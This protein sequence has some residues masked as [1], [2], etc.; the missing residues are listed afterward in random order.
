MAHDGSETS[1]IEQ[2]IADTLAALTDSGSSLPGNK[3]FKTA[4]KWT[5][6]V[7]ADSSGAEAF[8]RYAPFAFVSYVPQYA[9]REGGDDLRQP[10]EFAVAIGIVSK[11]AGVARFG[12][13]GILGANKIEQLVI[14]AIDHKRP[15]DA[16]VKC[17]DL[18]F[19]GSILV[20]DRPTVRQIQ[21]NFT[22]DRTGDLSA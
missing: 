2:W 12:D 1:I 15:S 17:D 11:H 6:Q 3:V 5:G 16:T 20:I 4:D 7:S 9:F 10:L 21:M 19:Q 22:A 14:A 8:I 18:K 13:T